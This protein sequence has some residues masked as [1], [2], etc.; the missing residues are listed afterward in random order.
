MTDHVEMRASHEISPGEII[1]LSLSV[2]LSPP[3]GSRSS[4]TVGPGLYDH[5]ITLCRSASFSPQVAQEA[6]EMPTIA[7]LVAGRLGVSLVP[8][9]VARL[10]QKGIMHRPL[11]GRGPYIELA[12]AWRTDEASKAAEAFINVAREVSRRRR[13]PAF[14]PSGA[15]RLN[16]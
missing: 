9:S 6:V 14:V 7:S 4:V 5:I 10:R 12:I 13:G 11:S 8:E 15:D 2:R 1:I 16:Q 3:A